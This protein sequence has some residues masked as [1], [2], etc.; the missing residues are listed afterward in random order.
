[1]LMLNDKT[2]DAIRRST[3]LD[4]EKLSSM[5][6]EEIDSAIEKKIGKSLDVGA[7]ENGAVSARGN[8]YIH[9]GRL[10]SNSWIEKHL[11]SI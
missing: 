4:P 6:H 9:S 11:S 5:D 2:K 1:M 7:I 3:G 8:V 10:I